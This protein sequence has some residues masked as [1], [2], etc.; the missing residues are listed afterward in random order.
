MEEAILLHD[1]A[2]SILHTPLSSHLLTQPRFL[3]S[4]PLSSPPSFY[5]SYINFAAVCTIS[6]ANR[7]SSI[8]GDVLLAAAFVSYAGA[9]GKDYRHELWRN[10]YCA[11]LL[12]F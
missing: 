5:P 11:A 6:P 10:R 3:H 7:G 4:T 9:F 1:R 2:L 12:L 8:V